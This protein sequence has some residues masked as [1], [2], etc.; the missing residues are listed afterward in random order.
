MNNHHFIEMFIYLVM[1]PVSISVEMQTGVPCMEFL[2][3]DDHWKESYD[4][5]YILL[6]LQVCSIFLSL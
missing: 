3:N 4:I 1:Y 2:T 5:A 6:Q